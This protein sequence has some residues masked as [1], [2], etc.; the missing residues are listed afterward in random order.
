MLQPMEAPTASVP[1]ALTA[2]YKKEA[3]RFAEYNLENP[4]VFT[5]KMRLELKEA[6]NPREYLKKLQQFASALLCQHILMGYI[7]NSSYW[8]NQFERTKE[9]Y[10]RFMRKLDATTSNDEVTLV[11][12]TDEQLNIIL[13]HWDI[14]KESHELSPEEIKITFEWILDKEKGTWLNNLGRS[15]KFAHEAALIEKHII[16]LGDKITHII[17]PATF[18]KLISSPDKL[19]ELNMDYLYTA[20]QNL[21]TFMTLKENPHANHEK[22]FKDFRRNDANI[23]TLYRATQS[24]YQTLYTI[25]RTELY[26]N[27]KKLMNAGEKNIAEYL[28][29]F[30]NNHAIKKAFRLPSLFLWKLF[31]NLKQQLPFLH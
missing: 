8:K 25:V 6:S 13:S 10:D 19:V 4:E 16:A 26:N 14:I 27:F 31:L 2:E 17:L 22:A 9:Q 15:I 29:P 5:K 3:K 11:P 7:T 21:L 1:Y 23:A 12:E 18:S 24:W 30:R 28:L 20:T